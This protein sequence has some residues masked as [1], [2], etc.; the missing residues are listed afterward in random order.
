MYALGAR[1]KFRRAVQSLQRSNWAASTLSPTG[2]LKR[3]NQKSLLSHHPWTKNGIEE[4]PASVLLVV[5]RSFSTLN[6]SLERSERPGLFTIPGLLH[7]SDFVR[8]ASVAIEESDRLRA[9]LSPETE[10]HTTSQARSVLYE[11]DKI[12]KTVCN[13]IDASELCR[14]VHASSE[15]RD[16]AQ[17]AFTIL[18]EYIGTLNGDES[19]YACLVN[20]VNSSG[21]MDLSEEEQRFATLLKFEFELEGIHLP[22]ETKTQAQQLQAHVV[23]LETMFIKNITNIDNEFS[24]DRSSVEQLIPRHTLKAHGAKYPAGDEGSQIHLSAS[25]PI[26]HSITSF[27]P[28]PNLRKDVYKETATSCPENLDVLNNLQTV[29]HELSNLLGFPSYSHRFLQDKMAKTP[30]NVYQFLQ[31]LQ[32]H[33]QPAFQ[34][35]MELIS[36]VKSQVEG[37]SNA[38]VEPWDLK[39][40]VKLLKAQKG[41]DPSQLTPYL[42]LQ[43][44]IDGMKFLVKQL[45][46]IDMSEEKLCDSERWDGDGGAEERIR[47]FVFRNAEGESL[48][49]MYLDPYPRQG[50]YTHAAHFTVRCG[51]VI[52]GPDSEYQ[53]P[54]VALVCNSSNFST[55]QEV[56][57]L[58]HEFGHAL[59]SLLSRTKFQHLSGTRVSMDFVETPSHWMEY[60]VWDPTFLPFL[61]KTESGEPIPFELIT[62]MRQSQTLFQSVELQ[63]QIILATFDQQLFGPNGK[64]DPQSTIA[65]WDSLHRQACVP[66][67]QGSHY[68]S[69]VGHLVSYGAGYYGYLYSQV[70]ASDIWSQLFQSNPLDVTAGKRMW[71]AVLRHGGAR[72]ANDI[73]EDLLGRAPQVDNYLRTL[74]V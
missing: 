46:E 51:C 27:A 66:H 29:R 9:T 11:L 63:N 72:D 49:T 41:I 35:D 42:S 74:K 18:Q 56:E 14:N 34:K 36:Y 23:Q 8:L 2:K 57:T 70:F 73:L 6:A 67:L 12:S 64:G 16:E 62:A 15:W 7:P 43:N 5:G 40:Y 37:T 38:I 39:Y 48:G 13:V 4:N 65:L 3:L 20:V 59:H 19:L 32:R 44:C 24:V 55:H 28:N 53:Q 45:F 54:I 58:W 1:G 69:T 26:S 22:T 25:S 61:A 17:R 52:D 10:I 68:H 50:K 71:N 33:I 31:Q 21:F 47:K 30:D 60:F